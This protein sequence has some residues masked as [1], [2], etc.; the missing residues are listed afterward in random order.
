MSFDSR[1]YRH[2]DGTEGTLWEACTSCKRDMEWQFYS[3]KHY[4][5]M[6]SD[7]NSWCDLEKHVLAAGYEF[8]RQI[9]NP[10]RHDDGWS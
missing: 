10:P 5:C 9:E 4:L 1:I 3:T 6:N 2:P 7:Y 8:V